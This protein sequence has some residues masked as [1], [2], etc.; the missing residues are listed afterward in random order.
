MSTLMQQPQEQRP[1]SRALTSQCSVYLTKLFASFAAARLNRMQTIRTKP[2]KHSLPGLLVVSLTSYSRRFQQLSLTL[3]SLLRQTTSPDNII[4][5]IADDERHLL[6][7]NVTH[8]QRYGLTIASC[9]DIFSYKKLI[10]TLILFPHAFIVTVDDDLYL[11][12]RWLEDIVSEYRGDRRVVIGARAHWI[13]LAEGNQPAPY[14]TWGYEQGQSIPSPHNF[15][16]TGAGVLFPPDVFH[17]SVLNIDKALSLCRMADDV[18]FYWMFRLNGAMAK[19]TRRRHRLI[20]WNQKQ[21]EPL[22]RANVCGGGNDH[23]LNEMHREF[24]FPI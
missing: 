18:W 21:S 5:W 2:Q 23:A 10:P 1:S 7:E 24:G 22:W 14:T 3:K 4:L 6:P 17:P 20:E 15:P 9:P 16:T 11:Y 8:L 13:A 19:A 12:P